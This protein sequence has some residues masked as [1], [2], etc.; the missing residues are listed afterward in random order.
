M[1]A[2]ALRYLSQAGVADRARFISM[3]F[4]TSIEPGA[5]C[6]LLKFIIHDWNDAGSIAI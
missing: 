6:Y 3:E 1:Q 4:F 2:N 5:D